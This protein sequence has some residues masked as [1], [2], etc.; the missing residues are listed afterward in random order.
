MK[1]LCL[2][3]IFLVI[4]PLASA[5]TITSVME[6]I[7]EYYYLVLGDNAVG[8]DVSAATEIVLGLF[9]HN[10]LDVETVLEGEVSTNL[11]RIL[12]GP[13]CGSEYI[14]EVLG[15]NCDSWPYE[16]GQA[17][18]KVEGNNIIVTGTTAND[19]RRAGLILREYPNYPILN[20]HSFILV[21]GNSLESASLDLEKAKTKNEFVCGDGICEPGEAF[22]CFPD[23]NKKTCFTICQ[24]EGFEEAF[25]RDVPSN[26]EV[27]ICQDG[28]KNK[29]LQYCTSE[30]SCCCKPK[31]TEENIPIQAPIQQPVIQ[32]ENF[33]TSFLNGDSAGLIV[34]ISLVILG[35]ILLLAFILTR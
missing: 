23:C 17:L 35:F 7:D 26:P 15:Y 24:D 9:K 18:I 8:G 19:R 29:G 20:N 34:T 32:E 30:K 13:P 21:S 25:C 22:L 27:N 10:D 28:E 5:A 6:D 14:V 1:R 2:L 4:L 31:T 11:P 16:E 33:L 12:V 3:F